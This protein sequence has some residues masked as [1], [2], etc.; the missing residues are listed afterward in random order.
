M[1]VSM[2]CICILRVLILPLSTILILDFRIFLTVWYFRI[3][4]TV[5]YFRIV[6]TVWYF[7]FISFNANY[8]HCT[9]SYIWLL[10]NAMK[11]QARYYK[12]K[13]LCSRLNLSLF[14]FNNLTWRGKITIYIHLPFLKRTIQYTFNIKFKKFY[15]II[16]L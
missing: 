16:N 7:I 6:L 8:I 1:K 14:F 12:Y 3:V 15:I 5:W 11:Q 13:F 4:L 9:C 2:S 10:Q